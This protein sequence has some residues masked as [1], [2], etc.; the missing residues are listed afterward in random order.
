MGIFNGTNS[1]TI[2][3]GQGQ[4]AC[5]TPL[6][7]ALWLLPGYTLCNFL[8]NALG[9]YITKHGSAVLRYISYALILP[10]ATMV[11]SPVFKERITVFTL[12]GLVTVIVGFSLYQ[13]FHAMESFESLGENQ[14]TGRQDGE[15][16]KDSQVN[17]SGGIGGEDV[18]ALPARGWW[19]ASSKKEATHGNG[20]R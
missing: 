14:K 10:M 8:Y 15:A 19:E 6:G 12:I 7:P 18:G 16:G 17:R 1:A 5:P 20:Q 2:C 13:R 11:G 4:I 9:L 3:A